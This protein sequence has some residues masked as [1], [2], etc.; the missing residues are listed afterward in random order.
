MTNM[1]PYR[2]IWPGLVLAIVSVASSAGE[3]RNDPLL[4]PVEFGPG[5]QAKCTMY[6]KTYRP[7]YP[8][9]TGPG[10]KSEERSLSVGANEKDSIEVGF[11]KLDV[12]FSSGLIDAGA[13]NISVW[14]DDIRLFAALRAAVSIGIV[15]RICDVDVL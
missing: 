1:T 10:V 4:E 5:G 8:K 14:A 7:P 13:V 2:K 12:S 3:S 11:L 6:F 15:R 9:V